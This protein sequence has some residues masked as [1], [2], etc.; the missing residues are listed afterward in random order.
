M[1]GNSRNDRTE[2]WHGAS[3]SDVLETLET[4]AGG[5]SSA[6]ASRRLEEYGENDIREAERT[7]RVELLLTQFRNPLMYLLVVA[8]LLSLGV[9]LFPESEPNYAEAAFI[10][11][12]LCV[13]GLSLNSE[14]IPPFTVGVN[15]VTG[16]HK[17][18]SVADWIFYDN[19][20]H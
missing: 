5:L 10:A 13:N 15:R 8:A 6:E 17:S 7:S 11:L 1:T 2:P 14:R 16:L 3:T 19:P 18:P 4:D 9:G 20:H 12:I